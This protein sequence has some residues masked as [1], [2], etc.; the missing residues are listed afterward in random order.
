M[1]QLPPASQ[2]TLPFTRTACSPRNCV[3]SIASPMSGAMLDRDTTKQGLAD[4]A[5]PWC[6]NRSSGQTS[7]TRLSFVP[8]AAPTPTHASLRI[9][10]CIEYSSTPSTPSTPRG[11]SCVSSSWPPTQR[12]R[13]ETC[14]TSHPA[15]PGL[16][17]HEDCYNRG[18]HLLL[19]QHTQL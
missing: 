13:H 11:V 15:M 18:R 3:T 14:V 16:Y 1:S 8:C 5:L 19:R 6:H 12:T 4:A 2:L 10:V 17:E 9:K 7:T